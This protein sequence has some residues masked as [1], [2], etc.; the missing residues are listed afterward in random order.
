M[1]LPLQHVFQDKCLRR[2]LDAD[3][4]RV[5]KQIWLTF[6]TA[7]LYDVLITNS[8][9]GCHQNLGGKNCQIWQPKCPN[10]S[11]GG[12]DLDCPNIRDS[13]F[14]SQRSFKPAWKASSLC[15]DINK[16]IN[17]RIISAFSA[18]WLCVLTALVL[19]KTIVIKVI[20]I[21]LIQFIMD[22]NV[23][24]V[25]VHLRVRAR[26]ESYFSLSWNVKNLST[27]PALSSSPKC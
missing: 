12:L 23:I 4:Y 18:Q 13:W 20:I 2:I 15:H 10:N 6:L 27:C 22:I 14:C 8:F 9:I 5:S 21:K 26:P 11:A 19:E 3:Y 17:R 16:M 24:T 1:W 25:S 7:W